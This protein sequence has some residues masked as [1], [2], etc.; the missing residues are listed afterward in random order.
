M[1]NRFQ[2]GT[3]K[4]KGKKRM[5][6]GTFRLEERDGKGERIRKSI[7]LGLRKEFAT[8]S[9]IQKKLDVVMVNG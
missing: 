8:E 1:A 9:E 5:V 7:P 6:W 2:R 4:V 3:W